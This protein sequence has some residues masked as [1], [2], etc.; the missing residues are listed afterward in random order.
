MPRSTSSPSRPRA[1]AARPPAEKTATDVTVRATT[2]DARRVSRVVPFVSLQQV[3]LTEVTAKRADQVPAQSVPFNMNAAGAKNLSEG[4]L[5]VRVRLTFATREPALEITAVFA[6][7]YALS[8]PISDDDARAFAQLNAIFNAWPYWRE[9]VQSIATRM[10]LPPPV[11]PL[12][13][14]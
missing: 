11:V 2:A 12:M 14:I 9:L 13:K 10:G 4:R 3:I 1:A 8:K 7:V 6:L 5:D